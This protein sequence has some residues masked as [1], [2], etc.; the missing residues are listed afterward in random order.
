[1]DQNK[2]IFILGSGA[3]GLPLAAYLTN[4]GRTAIAVRTSKNDV[5]KSTVR[6]TVDNGTNRISASIETISLCNLSDLN[7]ILVIAAKS[8]ANKALALA[9]KEKG[10]TGPVVIM[11][12][13][14]GIEKPFF[15]AGFSPILRC[16]LYVTSEAGPE[17]K[18]TFRPITPS[19]IGKVHG[20]ES[21]LKECVEHL[22]SE[23]FPFRV[24]PDIQMEIWRKA[25]I[26]SIFNSICPLL[27]VDNGIFA[28]DEETASLARQLVRECLM[29]TNRLNIA[30]SES[31]VMQ[32]I[33]RI[34]K[35]SNQLISTLQDIRKGRETEIEFL[36]LEIARVA[37]SM[38]PELHL[39]RIELLG[40]MILAK[41]LQHRRP[42]R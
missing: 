3:I 1:M 28:R 14:L 21:G 6:V 32:Q 8:Y 18:F 19:P 10:A 20:T 27:D 5:P 40:K 29:V 26:N 16:V 39:P 17:C 7:G 37:A 31:D 4:A 2:I 11:Q 42:G 41:S 34:S 22:T 36:N 9:L 25:I 24:E 15:G 35:G 38:Q 13:G 23:E 12:N 30:L 33:M